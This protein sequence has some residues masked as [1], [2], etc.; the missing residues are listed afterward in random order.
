MGIFFIKIDYWYS[1]FGFGASFILSL[2]AASI[3]IYIGCRRESYLV[4]ILFLLFSLAMPGYVI[5]KL[6]E[7]WTT[8]ERIQFPQNTTMNMDE[9][10]IVLTWLAT[11]ALLWRTILVV[12]GVAICFNFKKGLAISKCYYYNYYHLHHHQYSKKYKLFN[13]EWL[14]IQQR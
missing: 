11:M 14:Q 8:E 1:Y 13:N 9:I 7:I 5:Y 12:T 3:S 4:Q 2:L 6:N 10:R